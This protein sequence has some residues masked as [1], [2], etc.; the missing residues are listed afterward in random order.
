MMAC[1]IV[2]YHLLLV[3]SGMGQISLPRPHSGRVATHLS[4]VRQ[5]S[6]VRHV[7]AL[8]RSL[9]PLATRLIISVFPS[10]GRDAAGCIRVQVPT[11][12]SV[13]APPF[14]PPK[15]PAGFTMHAVGTGLKAR[16]SGSGASVSGCASPAMTI[17]SPC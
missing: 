15:Q 2:R 10:L 16:R 6:C 8:G 12:S 3:R 11:L 17:L 14:V 7:I 5:R 1:C 4:C 9:R 13:I